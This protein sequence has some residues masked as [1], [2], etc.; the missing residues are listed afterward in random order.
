M[1]NRLTHTFVKMEFEK[2]NESMDLDNGKTLCEIC[3]FEVHKIEGCTY[4]DLRC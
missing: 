4:N 3:H 1:G 2:R